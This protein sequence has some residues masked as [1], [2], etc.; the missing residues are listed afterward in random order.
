MAEKLAKEQED[1]VVQ[2][3]SIDAWKP[4]ASFKFHRSMTKKYTPE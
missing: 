3:P 1:I 4:E 2:L